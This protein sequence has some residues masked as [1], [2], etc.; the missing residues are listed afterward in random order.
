MASSTSAQSSTLLQSGPS[1]S[2]L[3]DNAIAP[4]FGTLP[5]VGRSPVTPH[6]VDGEEIE[7]R[8]SLPIPNPMSPPA[9]ADAGPADDPLEPWS[10][11]QGFFVMPPYQMSPW[12]SSPSVSLA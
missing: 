12:A 3:H 6:L 4:V 2:M 5:Y 1:L 11:F 9:V 7:P 8:V 10:T